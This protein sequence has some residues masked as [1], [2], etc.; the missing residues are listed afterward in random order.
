[1]QTQQS[2][3]SLHG[4]FPL[5]TSIAFCLNQLRNKHI[6]FLNLGGLIICP[7]QHCIFIFTNK[8]LIR[9]ENYK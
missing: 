7:E 9:I 1:M 6:Q 2:C 3:E 8:Y 5:N 4:Y